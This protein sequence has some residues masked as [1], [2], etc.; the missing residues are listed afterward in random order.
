MSEPAASRTL[1]PL[2]SRSRIGNGWWRLPRSMGASRRLE[3]RP[4]RSAPAPRSLSSHDGNLPVAGESVADLSG[5]DRL[6]TEIMT[7][8]QMPGGQL[9]IA[10][11]DRLV[12]NR[13]F[14]TRSHGPRE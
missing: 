8:W 4:I 14:G 5:F 10:R 7:K 2:W 11:N 9:A 12:Y 6:M 1:P 13:G 3:T